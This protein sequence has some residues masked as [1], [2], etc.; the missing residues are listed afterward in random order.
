MAKNR[1]DL[2]IDIRE[3]AWSI[4]GLYTDGY[5][6]SGN[7]TESSKERLDI[8]LDG[9]RERR[10]QGVLYISILNQFMVISH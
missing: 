1:K 9:I 10:I 2:C 4:S 7:I 8:V 6:Y 5:F 3:N